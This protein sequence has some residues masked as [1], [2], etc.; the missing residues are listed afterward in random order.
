MFPVSEKTASIRQPDRA[1]DKFA[2]LPWIAE[3]GAYFGH[4]D[5]E[6]RWGFYGSMVPQILTE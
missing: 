3:A 4:V 1:T 5:R 6:D 2:G